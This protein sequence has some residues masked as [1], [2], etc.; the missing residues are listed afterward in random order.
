MSCASIDQL[1]DVAIAMAMVFADYGAA[2]RE[3]SCPAARY[4]CVNKRW[5]FIYQ[6]ACAMRLFAT[7]P[8]RRITHW[9]IRDETPGGNP[10]VGNLAETIVDGWVPPRGSRTPRWWTSGYAFRGGSWSGDPQRDS[11]GGPFDLLHG[12]PAPCLHVTFSSS[13][14]VTVRA[15]AIA[16]R[17]RPR[18]IRVCT[19]VD[20]DGCVVHIPPPSLQDRPET[21]LSL[22]PIHSQQYMQLVAFALPQGKPPSQEALRWNS[23]LPVVL[24]EPLHCATGELRVYILQSHECGWVGI[25]QMAFF[26]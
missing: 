2:P 12:C 24:P 26:A 17:N 21:G 6:N 25:N 20:H 18:L 19:G 22:A 23:A 3:P 15:I 1:P 13:R 11:R 14:P 9:T 10:G 7:N 4:T 16:A 5:H 8:L